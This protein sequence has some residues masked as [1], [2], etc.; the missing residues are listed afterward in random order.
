MYTVI[1]SSDP[2]YVMYVCSRDTGPDMNELRG[3]SGSDP[4]TSKLQ[5]GLPFFCGS[6]GR[7]G[8][9]C[10][11]RNCQAIGAIGPRVRICWMAVFHLCDLYIYMCVCACACVCVCVCVF[12]CM[13][14][15]MPVCR[16]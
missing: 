4:F 3:P 6:P 12:V 13:Y 8:D 15:C 5:Y 11:V 9:K 10:A 2:V 14:A 16:E 1:A 7:G